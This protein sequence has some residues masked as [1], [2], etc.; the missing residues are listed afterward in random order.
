MT[1]Q[2]YQ[3][4]EHVRII[5][6]S[7]GQC[8]IIRG[9]LDK[10]PAVCLA[11]YGL[12]RK[13]KA[14]LKEALSKEKFL[15]GEIEGLDESGDVSFYTTQTDVLPK[16]I[17]KLKEN[18]FTEDP[19]DKKYV[20]REKLPESIGVVPVDGQYRITENV[21]AHFRNKVESVFHGSDLPA[22]IITFSSLPT[23]KKDTPFFMIR[24]RIREGYDKHKKKKKK[25]ELR[26]WCARLLPEV[27]LVRA[28]INDALVD[29]GFFPLKDL[30]EITYKSAPSFPPDTIDGYQEVRFSFPF[31]LSEAQVALMKAALIEAGA[32]ISCVLENKRDIIVDVPCSYNLGGTVGRAFENRAYYISSYIKEKMNSEAD[33]ALMERK[34]SLGRSPQ[35]LRSGRLVTCLKEEPAFT[36]KLGSISEADVPFLFSKTKQNEVFLM[37]EEGNFI[38]ARRKGDGEVGLYHGVFRNSKKSSSIWDYYPSLV[39]IGKGRMV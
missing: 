23:T 31:D 28:D 29:I 22:D 2:Y 20:G 13:V 19:L 18:G 14:L 26:E 24:A 35:V 1:F 25:K 12:H 38:G 30:R 9:Q 5:D 7:Y 17:E 32:V 36:Q 3:E 4:T 21:D 10:T 15:E 8:Y 16:I 37:C 27:A 39:N 34:P 6:E 11:D 33:C